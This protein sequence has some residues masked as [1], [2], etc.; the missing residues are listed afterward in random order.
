MVWKKYTKK[1]VS[2]HHSEN[3]ALS[4]IVIGHSIAYFQMHLGD[5][6]VETS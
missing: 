3:I 1:P 2:K 4:P 6:V 5:P